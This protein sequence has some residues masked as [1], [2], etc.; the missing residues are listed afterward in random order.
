MSDMGYKMIEY[1]A[2]NWQDLAEQFI[3]K[4]RDA[5]EQ[6]VSD[7]FSQHVADYEPPDHIGE[8]R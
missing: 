5:W 1:E 4:N 8:D 6:F 7:K 2:N 3:E